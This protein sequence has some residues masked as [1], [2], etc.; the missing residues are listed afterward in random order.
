MG[1][2]QAE[3]AEP[4]FA[5]FPVRGLTATQNFFGGVT[6][7]AAAAT[8]MATGRKTASGVLAMD[9]LGI[10]AYRSI[11]KSARDS[12][13]KVGIVTTVS[14]D[15]S[16]PAAFYATSAGRN[17]YY[18]IALQIPAS[19]FDYFGG[20]T[21]LQPRGASGLKP[22]AFAL[23]AA[24]GYSIVDDAE[25]F[26]SLAPGKPA[27]FGRIFAVNSVIADSGSMPYDIDRAPGDL[28]FADYVA[29]GI[30]L[31]D[32]TAG[33]FM[34]A[35]AGKIDWACHD[36]NAAAAIGEVRA[37]DRAVAAALA[38]AARHPGEVL[39]VVTGDHETGGM[40]LAPPTSDA[41]ANVR[42]TSSGHTGV[43]VP[44]YASGT[45]Q[46]LFAGN[47]DNT[48]IF[49]KLS[50]VMGLSAKSSTPSRDILPRVR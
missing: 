12:G 32:G 11:A 30:E 44:T 19:G 43:P 35:E 42:W 7:S 21:L 37:L 17:D 9:P 2:V 16:T 34:M 25:A 31:L 50:A 45:G 8:A 14:L 28:S 49:R 1:A 26:R 27:G 48:D 23:I 46:N 3:A 38:F 47:Y 22:D 40:K 15:H 6:D 33:F 29:K 5:R 36:N 39:V 41:A 13:M 24:A 18:G 4:D 10:V 20:G